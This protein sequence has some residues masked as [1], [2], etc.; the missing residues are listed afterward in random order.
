MS[1]PAED[2]DTMRTFH[3]KIERLRQSQFAETVFTEETGVTLEYERGKPPGSEVRG[4]NQESIDAMVLTLR[5]TMQDNDRISLRRMAEMLE[6]YRTET[7]AVER[8]LDCRE[9]L[10]DFLGSCIEPSIKLGDDYLKN[11]QILRGVIYGELA[12]VNEEKAKAMASLREMPWVSAVI[13]NAFNVIVA[14]F[15]NALFYLQIQNREVYKELTGERLSISQP[16]K[17]VEE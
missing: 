14:E 10:N 11:E 17:L 13:D 2:L 12:H 7:P 16:E 5:L 6:K 3:E 4:P 15:L 1:A 8:F 9:K